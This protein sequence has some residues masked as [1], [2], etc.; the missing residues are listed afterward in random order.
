LRKGVG[1]KILWTKMLGNTWGDKG[2]SFEEADPGEGEDDPQEKEEEIREGEGKEGEKRVYTGRRHR[3]FKW[4]P[5]FQNVFKS[6]DDAAPGNDG[7]AVKE[8]HIRY[9]RLVRREVGVEVRWLTEGIVSHRYRRTSCTS[10]D[11][12]GRSS[13]ESLRICI[14]AGTCLPMYVL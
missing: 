6:V 12:R 8:G 1:E 3:N 13:C 5:R 10:M 7:W 2:S 4:A 14:R 11:Q 9:V